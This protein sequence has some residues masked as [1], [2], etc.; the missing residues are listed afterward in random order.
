GVFSYGANFLME[1]SVVENHVATGLD[2][3]AGVQILQ[4]DLDTH[5]E[6]ADSIIR[7][8]RGE[9]PG[10]GVQMRGAAAVPQSQPW[11]ITNSSIVENGTR[12]YFSGGVYSRNV[13]LDMIQ[14]TVAENWVTAEEPGTITYTGPPGIL[15]WS[16][17]GAGSQKLRFLQ[18][19]VAGN[20]INADPSI[21]YNVALGIW[22]FAQGGLEIGNS[23]IAGNY[24]TGFN[25]APEIRL[26]QTS[27]VY[28]TSL[29]G[30]IVGSML[31]AEE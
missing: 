14:S 27:P 9:G 15:H 4:G 10:A 31:P 23:I 24:R 7:N 1:R 25:N 30:N 2:Y 3:A 22:V 16:D 17:S 21:T 29:G 20:Y 12:F 26:A 6:I 18:S 5:A 13:A 8:N 11:R 28:L 19:T